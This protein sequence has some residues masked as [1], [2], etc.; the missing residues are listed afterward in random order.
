LDG[1]R[2][3]LR[4]YIEVESDARAR[5]LGRLVALL[6]KAQF[7]TPPFQA[8]F[9]ALTSSNRLPPADIVQQYG[10]VSEAWRQ[11]DAK[12]AFA[13][14]Q[15]ISTGPWAEAAARE[16]RHKR[17]IVEQYAALQRA[18]GANG[19]EERLLAFY[20]ALDPDEDVYFIRATEAD[21]AL[22]KDQALAQAQESLNR[23]QALWRQYRENGAIEG[24]QRLKAEISDEFRTQAR[25]LSE[26]HDDAQRGI[27]IYT[28]LK[29]A[30]PAQW[31]KVQE[32]IKAEAELQRKSL[33]DLR[34]VL[35]PGLLKARLALLGGVER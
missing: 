21:V 32:E 20:G 12:Q 26:A 33:L 19:Y 13:N 2:Q 7:S 16:L 23:A 8:K 27:R 4:Q 6:A 1:V 15:R 29:V 35:E 34:N 22:H 11:G 28:Q 14:L 24:R 25:L 31:T 17:A 18:R 5:R 3:D 9:L 30:R 10:S